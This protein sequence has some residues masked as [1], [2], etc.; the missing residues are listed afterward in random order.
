MKIEAGKYYRTRGGQV[1]GPMVWYE[2]YNAN[3]P[4]CLVFSEPENC[5]AEDG[6]WHLNDQEYP[7]D[8]VAEIYISDTPPAPQVNTTKTARDDLVEKAALAIL[9]GHYANPSPMSSYGFE[10][11]WLAAEHFVEA[12]KK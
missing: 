7:F 2:D 4:W 6:R 12:R 1:F 11:I 9:N 3:F 5:W 8:L 10:E